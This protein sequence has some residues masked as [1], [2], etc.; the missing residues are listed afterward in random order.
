MLDYSSGYAIIILKY[1]LFDADEEHAMN[2]SIDI[3]DT[4]LHTVRL[5]L[6]PWRTSDI[7]DLFAFTSQVGVGEMCGWQPHQDISEAEVM[8]EGLIER[9]NSFAIEYQNHTVGI[10]SIPKYDEVHFPQFSEMRGRELYFVLSRD[11][12]GQGFMQEAANEVIRFLFE[13]C[14]FDVI[15]CGHFVINQRS[16]RL[17]Q[18]LGFHFCGYTEYR[19]K[20]GSLQKNQVNCM[21]RT[22]WEQRR[23]P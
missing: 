15:F 6:R 22:E 7:N 11:H 19:T 20:S 18:K 4:V 8:L 10:F 1:H 17:Q 3:S 23:R 5:I 14:G 13:D 16:A 21:T 2:P 9:K 12:W